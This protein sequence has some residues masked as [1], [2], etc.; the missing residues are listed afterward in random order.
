[1]KRVIDGR[2]YNTDTAVVIARYG[3]RD[4]KGHD[5][6]VD[7]YQ[8]RGGAFFEV[9]RWEELDINEE[10]VARVYFEATSRH[11]IEELIA[12]HYVTRD[13]VEILDEQA[14]AA[15][16]EAEAEGEPAATIYFRLPPAL[17]SRVETMAKAAGLSVNAWMLRCVE[18]CTGPL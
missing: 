11:L 5:V 15:P 18:R 8:N 2:S 10:R 17:K 6:L 12:G 1:M 14:L 16:P 4:E 3:Y 9:H 7:I 13:G